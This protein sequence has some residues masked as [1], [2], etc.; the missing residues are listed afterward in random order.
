MPGSKRP[1]STP[2][3]DSP[4]DECERGRLD[5]GRAGGGVEPWRPSGAI[6]SES[7]NSVGRSAGATG[8]AQEGQKR[9]VSVMGCLQDVQTVTGG[10]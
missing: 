6:V 2:E 5:A 9:A 3:D 1:W 4:L 7:M 10:L 8:V